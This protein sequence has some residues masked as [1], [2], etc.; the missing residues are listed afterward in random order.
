MTIDCDTWPIPELGSCSGGCTIP[1][2]TDP[3]VLA[4]ASV[5]AGVIMH[6]LSGNQIGQCVHTIRPMD[7]CGCVAACFCSADRIRIASG[8]GPVTGIDS[9]YID[10]ELVDPTEYRFYPSSQLLYRLPP[11]TWPRNDEKWADCDEDGSFC[12]N[13]LVGY[14][15]DAWA[16]A[17][18]AE[19]TCELVKS[20]TDQKCRIPSNATQVTGQGVTVTLSATELK[21][22]IPAVAGWVAAVNPDSMRQPATV[23]SPDLD[24]PCAGGGGSS[25]SGSDWAI[26]GGWA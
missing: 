9:I 23:S 10:G 2:D 6:I 26:D 14:E 4:A 8:A 17:V 1:A 21:Q 15:P 16:L 5:Q 12:V 3:D 13:A 18:H 7:A 20:C 25:F 22:F 19:L 11:A 24:Q